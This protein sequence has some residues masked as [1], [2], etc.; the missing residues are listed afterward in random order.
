MDKLSAEKTKKWL[1]AE[2]KTRGLVL[3]KAEADFLGSNFGSNLWAISQ[4]LELKSLGGGINVQK[5]I[6]NPFGL[7]DLFILKKRREAYQ[8]FHRSLI[9]GVSA[10][11]MFWKFWWQVKTLLIVSAGQ[12]SRSDLH[13]FVVKKSLAALSRFK[14]EE[15]EKIWEDLFLLWRDSKSGKIELSLGLERLILSPS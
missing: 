2:A 14:R 10:E 13:P 15:L 1:E 6:Y 9:G 5:F 7:T 3:S 8:H 11:E 4:A 12:D